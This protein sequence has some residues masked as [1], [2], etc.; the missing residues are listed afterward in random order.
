M[1]GKNRPQTEQKITC[2][3]N[4]ENLL[5]AGLRERMHV[6]GFVTRKGVTKG[7]GPG[8]GI[9]PAD[10]YIIIEGK[11]RRPPRPPRKNNSDISQNFFEKMRN[12]TVPVT[13]LCYNVPVLCGGVCVWR[14]R[15]RKKMRKTAKF[16][17]F[18]TN[19]AG[20]G[21]PGTVPC[22]EAAKNFFESHEKK[23]P[24]NPQVT[25]FSP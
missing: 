21:R 24:T 14:I 18:L 17:P 19:R 3:R 22:Q 15:N 13:I 1:V 9:C 5:Q 8:R 6:T 23:R 2:K 7:R 12:V 10:R 16:Q 20:F 4:N 11:L 25:L